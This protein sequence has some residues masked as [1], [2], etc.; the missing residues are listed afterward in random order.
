MR[1]IADPS[2]V[3][4]LAAVSDWKS[5][6]DRAVNAI[7]TTA[8]NVK[9]IWCPSLGYDSLGSDVAGGPYT[10]EMLYPGDG[11]VDLVGFGGYDYNLNVTNYSQDDTGRLQRWKDN[12]SKPNG[13]QDMIALATAHNKPLVHI[14]WGLWPA[15]YLSQQGGGDDHI[16]M[17]ML[18]AFFHEHN[19]VLSVY[20]N[21]SSE[22]SL[23]TYPNAKKVY[24]SAIALPNK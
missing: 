18:G 15:S 9:I 6:F 21:S 14:E 22:H 5:G 13:F 2:A 19:V 1:V 20:N 8:P 16:Y 3:N 24:T 23:S 7:K 17:E 11:C 12:W 4:I 10:L